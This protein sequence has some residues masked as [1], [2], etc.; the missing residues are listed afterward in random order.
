MTINHDIDIAIYRGRTPEL[1]AA[2][3][4]VVI[5]VIRAF[6]TTHIA[7]KRGACSIWLAESLDDA[8]RLA[9]DGSGRLLAG[10]RNALAPSGFDLGNSPAQMAGADVAGREVVL[11]TTNGVQ[12]T[13]HA[14]FDGPL[15]V[16]G[17][18]NAGATLC[19]L[20]R[21]VA[22]GRRRIELIA[23][24]PSGDEDLA[25]ARWLSARLRGRKRPR[26][27]EVQRRIRRSR[28]AEKFLDTD[29]PRYRAADIE[30]CARRDDSRWPMVA[31]FRGPEL[32]VEAR[33]H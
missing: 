12:A 2:D 17:F 18:S 7:L 20:R 31:S 23:S 13:L 25:C 26:D 21:L 32:V 6:T 15:I 3:I 16:T 30:F 24:H 29:R 14:A 8:R 27:Q 28:A 11:T 19:H 5:D 9:A 22:G 1:K 10:E 33:A 4:R